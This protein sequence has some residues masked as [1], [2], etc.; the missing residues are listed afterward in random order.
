VERSDRLPAEAPAEG[1]TNR[2]YG[3]QVARLAGL[4]KGVVERARQV[5]DGL[6]AQALR[7]GGRGKLD[8]TASQL[9]AVRGRGPGPAGPVASAEAQ[10]LEQ[11][12][13]LGA[14]RSFTSGRP[15]PFL[16]ELQAQLEAG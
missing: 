4:P 1:A 6:E 5:L 7:S 8:V 11:P 3:V 16:A 2:S 10:V 9:V 13:G 12:A 15:R 14:R